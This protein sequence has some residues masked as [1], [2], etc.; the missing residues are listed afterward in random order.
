[1]TDPVRLDEQFAI[2]SE[3]ETLATTVRVL[4][5]GDSFAVFD[6]HGDI[7]PVDGYGLYHADTRVLS[8][9]ELLLGNRRPLLL[10]STISEDNLVFAADL[11]NPDVVKDGQL[12]LARGLL[13]VL[14]SRVMFDGGCIDRISVTGYGDRPVELTLSLRFDADFADIFEVRGSRRPR[15]G[16]PLPDLEEADRV[17][18]YR[19]LDGVVRRTRIRSMRPVDRN[20][21][22]VLSYRLRLDPDA[23]VEIE[24]AI[25]CEVGDEAR[26]LPRYDEVF[27]RLSQ[28]AAAIAER[29]GRRL[30]VERG[31]QPLALPIRGRSPHDDH[32][33]VERAL[34]VRGHSVVQHPV[35]P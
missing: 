8:A 30:H 11:T 23:A 26:P 20:H 28:H 32:R 31:L 5:H 16:E 6:P 13:H 24:V 1:M 35:R 7:L 21:D 15:R 17:L 27:S 9:F 19:G 3:S 34:S 22:A 12:V 18:R 14:R 4:K 29:D 2:L 10:S 33:D 25:G